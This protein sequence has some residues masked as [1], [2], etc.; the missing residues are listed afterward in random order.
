MTFTA[1]DLRL[2]NIALCLFTIRV[3][4]HAALKNGGD[5][6]YD[7]YFKFHVLAGVGARDLGDRAR[8]AKIAR[9]MLAL[10]LEQAAFLHVTAAIVIAVKMRAFFS[11]WGFHK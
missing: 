2:Q 6:A 10:R 8:E 1:A 4:L 11:S 3:D 7:L 9:P 5:G